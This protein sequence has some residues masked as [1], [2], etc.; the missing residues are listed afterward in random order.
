MSIE[1]SGSDPQHNF[2]DVIEGINDDWDEEKTTEILAADHGVLCMLHW[3]TTEGV[4][5]AEVEEVRGFLMDRMSQMYGLRP[6]QCDA[7]L[8][9]IEQGLKEARQNGQA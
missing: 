9:N 7:A 8:N 1:R 3:A 6:E 2:W 4:T 5:K